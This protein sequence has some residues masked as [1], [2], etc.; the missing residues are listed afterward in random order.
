MQTDY[1]RRNAAVMKTFITCVYEWKYAHVSTS[2]ISPCTIII[3]RFPVIHHIGISLVW[4]SLDQSNI[5]I[6]LFSTFYKWNHREIK[7]LPFLLEFDTQFPSIRV[8][9][10]QFCIRVSLPVSPPLLLSLPLSHFSWNGY[11][12]NV[13]GSEHFS[14]KV[15]FACIHFKFTIYVIIK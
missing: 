2:I 9:F 8:F 15:Y 14:S 10:A 3:S 4:L 6:C 13:D 1:A 12:F 5:K 11:N 7:S